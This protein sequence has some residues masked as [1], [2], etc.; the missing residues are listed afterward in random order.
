MLE[1]FIAK[2]VEGIDLNEEESSQAMEL[3]MTGE[4]PPA[5]IASFITA[6]R[7]KGETISEITGF[8]KT[9]RK[10]AVKIRTNYSQPI[11]DTC[12]TGGD[13]KGTFNISTAVAFVVAGGGCIVAKHHNRSVSSRCGSAD[14]LEVLGID[15][16]FPSEKAEISLQEFGLAF[17]FAPRFHPAT[18]FAVGPRKDI[19]IRTV[20]NLLGPLTNPADAK[21]HLVGIYRRDLT[22]SIAQVLKN[23]G[24]QRAMVVHSE[25][26]CD[27]ISISGKTLVSELKNGAIKTYV[28]EPEMFGLKRSPIDSIKGG[29]PQENAKIIIDILD[30]KSGPQ[31]DIVLLNA[32]SVFLM[33]GKVSTIT[34]GIKM[35]KESIDSGS[36]RKKLHEL[37]EFSKSN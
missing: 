13:G 21:I 28:I 23:L 10:N 8:A 12:G 15:P 35:A 2:V 7:M 34:D 20:F 24:S 27:E 9:M 1:N 31:R 29:S 25:E 16:D 36:A 26:G 5:Q 22:Q 17:L 6:L 37:Q 32:A 3:I 18:R 19:G 30:G 33:A 4:V 14:V 11:I